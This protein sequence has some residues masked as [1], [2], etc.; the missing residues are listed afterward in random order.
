MSFHALTAFMTTQAQL[1]LI[2]ASQGEV[3]SNR[4]VP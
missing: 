3:V 2:G 1:A 4:L